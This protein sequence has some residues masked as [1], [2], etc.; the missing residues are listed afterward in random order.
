MT[1]QSKSKEIGVGILG[2]SIGK[3]HAYGWQD[4]ARVL[5]SCKAHPEAGSASRAFERKRRARSKEVWDR[6]EVLQVGGSC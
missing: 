4:L 6:E 5:L 1:E 2:Y 3:A